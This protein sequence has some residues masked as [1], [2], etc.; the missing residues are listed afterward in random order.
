MNN[1][2]TPQERA[3]LAKAEQAIQARFDRA[4]ELYLAGAITK[5]KYQA[6]KW[7]YQTDIGSFHSRSAGQFETAGDN[8]NCFG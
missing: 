3:A 4:T 8:L 2:F 6:E 5:E 1:H 7:Q